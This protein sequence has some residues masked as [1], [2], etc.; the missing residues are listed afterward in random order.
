MDA[1]HILIERFTRLH[2]KVIDLSLGRIERLL[3]RLGQPHKKLPPVIHV[4]GTNGKGSTIAFM[5][6]ILESAGLSVHVYTSPHLVNFHERIRLGHIGG[7]Q[8]VDEAVLA[9]ALERCETANADE[10]ITIFEMTTAAA[11]L[12]Y[13]E[14][15][16]DILLL[17]TGLGGRL[18]ATNVIEHPV[19]SVITSIG[20]DHPEFLGTDLLSLTRE[21]AGIMKRDSSVVIAPQNYENVSD[22]LV[23]EAQRIGARPVYSGGQDFMIHNERGRLIYQD[24]SC[25]MDLPMPR[26]LGRHQWINA[27]T[28]IAAVRAAG[29]SDFENRVFE[30]GLERVEWPARLQPLRSGNLL[31]YAPVGADIW[32]DGGHN[33]DGGRV[34]AEAMADIGERYP[35]PLVLIC[36]M[37]NTKDSDNFFKAFLG[38]VRQVIAVPVPDNSHTRSADE[39]ALI[40]QNAGLPVV[41]AARN[42]EAA[43]SALSGQDWHIPPRILICGSLYLAGHVLGMNGTPPQ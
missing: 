23:H 17:E 12:L 21:K 19:V 41:V 1:S 38:L 33:A 25:L 11:F 22:S 32:L 43:L 16:A 34:L 28:A 9:D 26:L 3:D 10:P 5:R 31:K 4:A 35:A 13:S 37:L 2:P 6:A 20:Y 24:L 29:Y 14:Y 39:T 30:Q 27:G 18:D 36:G 15:F 8:L 40:A 7:G 42:V